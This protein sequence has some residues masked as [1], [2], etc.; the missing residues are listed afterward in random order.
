MVITP[1]AYN[2][3]AG[4]CLACP[5]TN[6]GKGYPFEVAIPVGLGVT[7]VILADQVRSLSW[8]ERN[9]ELVDRADLSLVD[10]VREKIAALIEIE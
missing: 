6:R 3:R 1:L 5:L 10:D 8:P 2:Q 4:L 7:G 9:A